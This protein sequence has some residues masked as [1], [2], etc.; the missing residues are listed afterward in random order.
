MTFS[1]R[2]NFLFSDF[3]G[4]YFIVTARCKI[5]DLSADSHIDF[6]QMEACRVFRETKG[7]Q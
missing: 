1:S 6:A 4:Q 7:Y 2:D 3:C 5:G